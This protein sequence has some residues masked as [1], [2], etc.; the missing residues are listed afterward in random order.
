[1]IAQHHLDHGA[2]AEGAHDSKTSEDLRTIARD[3]RRAYDRFVRSNLRLVVSIAKR[4]SNAP[5]ELEDALQEGNLGLMRA[6]EKFDWTR[7]NKFSTYATWWIRQAITRAI[8]DQGRLVRI[9]VHA[10]EDIARIRA[11]RRDLMDPIIGEATD[12]DVASALDLEVARIHQLEAYDQDP[13]SLNRH[14][15][16]AEGP[17]E[18][19]DLLQDPLELPTE[20]R[21]ERDELVE[22]VRAVIAALPP[23]ERQIMR[24]RNGL[25]GMEQGTLDSIGAEFG[26]TRERIRQLE[27]KTIKTLKQDPFL[28][29]LIGDLR[30]NLATSEAIPRVARGRARSA[31]PSLASL[32]KTS[33]DPEIGLP[34]EARGFSTS[35][36][37]GTSPSEVALTQAPR[38]PAGRE[39]RGVDLHIRLA[40]VEAFA[41]NPDIAS[42]SSRTKNTSATVIDVLA[43]ITGE[44]LDRITA[45]PQIVTVPRR[46]LRKLRDQVADASQST[47]TG[48]LDREAR[49]PAADPADSADHPAHDFPTSFRSLDSRHK[50]VSTDDSTQTK[51]LDDTHIGELERIDMYNAT[52][53]D[54][55]EV[56]LT[57]DGTWSFGAADSTTPTFRRTRWGANRDE[58]AS[59]EDGK[60]KKGPDGSLT[61]KG[62]IAHL[63]TKIRYELLN[64]ALMRAEYEIIEEFSSTNK[65]LSEFSWFKDLL[66]KKYGAP[67]EDEITWIDESSKDE[68]NEWGD[69]VARGDLEL[70]AVWHSPETRVTAALKGQ[71]YETSMTITYDA[72][73]YEHIARAAREAEIL[74]DL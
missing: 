6:V 69:A 3:G 67:I 49:V 62:R 51:P 9:P 33:E 18:L 58:I 64:D 70:R 32:E 28:L 38:D 53:E 12:D 55:T 71:N 61:Y 16:T 20:A 14:V 7:G 54:G 45:E 52:L 63:E 41:A 36:E 68:P 73:R 47:E 27:A 50:P 4:Y 43:D 17:V 30:G 8:A 5:L 65:Y 40:I 29:A 22:T 74:A 1:M 60:P 19:G 37:L 42:V 56:T 57:R 26:V 25:D 13:D 15:W 24:R 10:V 72:V 34:R 66:T 21:L 39:A 23:R 59:S 35:I 2:D 46:L 48:S 11:T 31:E 44:S